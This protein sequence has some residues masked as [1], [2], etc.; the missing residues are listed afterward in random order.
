MEIPAGKFKATCLKLMDQ[1]Q[2]A[3]E[4]IIITKR[5]RPVAKLVPVS[6]SPSRPVFGFLK[7]SVVI[8]GDIVES[9][10]AVWEADS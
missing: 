8:H 9:T 6:D 4:E 3:H 5:G 10:G 1:L 7:D 2:E